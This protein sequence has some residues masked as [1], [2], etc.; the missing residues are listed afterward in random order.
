[1][2]AVSNCNVNIEICVLTEV[3][4]EYWDNLIDWSEMWTLRD[5][6]WL[7]K[8]VNIEMCLMTEVQCEYWDVLI[9]LE[10]CEY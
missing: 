3:K 2:S 4:C 10:K 6:Y 9:D 5:A 8:N 7:E 1:M